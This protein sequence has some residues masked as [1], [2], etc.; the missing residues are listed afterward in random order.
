MKSV[1]IVFTNGHQSYMGFGSLL[2]ATASSVLFVP[3]HDIQAP[4]CRRDNDEVVLQKLVSDIKIL[5]ENHTAA[6]R[7][8]DQFLSYHKD[9][10]L[11]AGKLLLKK[12]DKITRAA[13]RLYAEISAQRAGGTGETSFWGDQ[14]QAIDMV[15][16]ELVQMRNCVRERI[17]QPNAS[18]QIDEM[19]R[20]LCDKNNALVT[21]VSDLQNQQPIDSESV[22]D[23]LSN[24]TALFVNAVT[25]SNHLNAAM[26]RGDTKREMLKRMIHIATGI[27]KN[28]KRMWHDVKC[29][30]TA[31]AAESEPDS[32]ADSNQS[33]EHYQESD[34]NIQCD[35]SEKLFD[36][37]S[38]MDDIFDLA[39]CESK[40]ELLRKLTELQRKLQ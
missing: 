39:G 38:V 17:E 5:K 18:V 12:L 21:Q 14:L 9:D 8:V 25:V 10:Y 33:N 20:A 1:K 37:K 7:V 16:H 2:S 6:R 40:E 27:R 23:L 36:M 30:S 22:R 19:I 35:E 4:Y 29:S 13:K 3:K 34:S 26:R 32:C 28:C 31:S 24:I 15:W 11:E